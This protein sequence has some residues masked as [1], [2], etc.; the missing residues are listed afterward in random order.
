MLLQFTDTFFL[1]GLCQHGVGSTR[2]AEPNFLLKHKCNPR[3]KNQ[4][5]A[6]SGGAEGGPRG[7]GG[8]L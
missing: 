6:D 5:D 8:V 7:G 1:Y 3:A 4:V 2:L